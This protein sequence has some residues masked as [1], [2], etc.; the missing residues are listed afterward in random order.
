[1]AEFTLPA[2]GDAPDSEPTCGRCGVTHHY[3]R[4]VTLVVDEES[5]RRIG[6]IE[7]FCV[8]CG[9]KHE[10]AGIPDRPSRTSDDDGLTNCSTATEPP[11]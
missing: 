11:E 10:Q 7:W 2:P 3:G 9:H 6:Q 5:D 4:R 1:M 8:E